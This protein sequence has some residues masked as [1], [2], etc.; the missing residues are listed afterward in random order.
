MSVTYHS[1]A[2][3]E[4]IREK[5]EASKKKPYKL[6]DVVGGFVVMPEGST[7]I[8][9]PANDAAPAVLHMPKPVWPVIL[10]PGPKTGPDE[11]LVP[12]ASKPKPLEAGT[13]FKMKSD[14]HTYCGDVV[15]E[16]NP[17]QHVDI[18]VIYIG[19]KQRF[20]VI[21][22]TPTANASVTTVHTDMSPEVWLDPTH[23]GKPKVWALVT[24]ALD[25]L[26][27][28]ATG[29]GVEKPVA[30]AAQVTITVKLVSE[31]PKFFSFTCDG[32]ERWLSKSKLTSYEVH[33]MDAGKILKA[34]VPK[35]VLSGNKM[36]GL[37]Q[38]PNMASVS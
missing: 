28:K 25:A 3:A 35:H 6:W 2:T 33:E 24:D 27:V 23:K 17:T 10:E 18:Q 22:S 29:L 4:K 37:M 34:T 30:A 36:Y 7:P 31:T 16:M 13:I 26:L 20:R 11:T 5:L 9:P 14:I 21:L 15:A 1:R 32:K 19:S 8:P 12:W 38:T